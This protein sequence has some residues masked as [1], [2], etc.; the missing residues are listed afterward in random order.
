MLPSCLL[1]S[2]TEHL[3]RMFITGIVELY[4]GIMLHVLQ[5]DFLDMHICNDL[6][7]SLVSEM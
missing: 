2:Y 5:S 4:H 7:I 1:L 6:S 3:I